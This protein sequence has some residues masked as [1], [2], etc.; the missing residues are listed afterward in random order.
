LLVFVRAD[1][2][3]ASLRLERVV[4]S[5]ARVRRA[6]RTL[7]PLWLDVTSASAGD[8]QRML[9]FGVVRPPA[10]VLLDHRGQ[11]LGRLRGSATVAAV[12]ELLGR[13]AGP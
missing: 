8:E 10:I 6:T 1:W 3:A 4:W 12:L 11:P 7:V 5:D 9:R 13:V 2:S